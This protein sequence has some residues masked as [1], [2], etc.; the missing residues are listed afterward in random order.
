MLEKDLPFYDIGLIRK[1]PNQPEILEQDSEEVESIYF[2]LS[3]EDQGFALFTYPRTLDASLYSEMGNVLVSYWANERAMN[4]QTSVLISS[5]KILN[6]KQLDRLK[7]SSPI[8]S[9]ALEHDDNQTRYP[10]A[11]QIFLRPTG[12]LLDV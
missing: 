11:L 4:N 3:G 8:E 1:I 5:P 7:F 12:G 9:Y 6:H 2:G 10:I